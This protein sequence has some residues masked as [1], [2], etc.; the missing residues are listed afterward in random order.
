[1]TKPD[2]RVRRIYDEPEDRDG[3]RVLVDRRWPRG[4]TKA[5]AA[6]DEWCKTV[7]PSTALRK[8]YDHDPA[9]FDEFTCRYR[10]ELQEPEPAEAFRHLRQLSH[11]HRLTLLTATKDVDL[12]QAAV[13]AVLLRSHPSGK[14]PRQ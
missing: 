4:V 14:D 1:M 12:S 10:A 9:K 11:G 5:K 3:I 13:L 2:V 6:L 8:W 7:P